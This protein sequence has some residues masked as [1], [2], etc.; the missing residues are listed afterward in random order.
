MRADHRV[1]KPGDRRAVAGGVCATSVPGDRA[2]AGRAWDLL[3]VQPGAGGEAAV[4]FDLKRSE[5]KTN[6]R[7]TEDIEG[8][9]T[10]KKLDFF[11][12]SLPSVSSV[13]L[14]FVLFFRYAPALRSPCGTRGSASCSRPRC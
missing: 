8:R 14:W 4:G 11:S 10:E 13:P 2:H 3:R 5:R 12:V 6:H 7:G 1:S 9:D